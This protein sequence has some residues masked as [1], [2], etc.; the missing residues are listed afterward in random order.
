MG[1]CSA[2]APCGPSPRGPGAGL[3]AGPAASAANPLGP[4]A[5]AAEPPRRDGPPKL[6]GL[7]IVN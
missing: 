2:K 4:A 6:C 5:G 3:W 1:R 7:T